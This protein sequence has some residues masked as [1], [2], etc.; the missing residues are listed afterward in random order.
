MQLLRDLQGNT[1]KNVGRQVDFVEERNLREFNPRVANQAFNR[2]GARYPNTNGRSNNT[3][4]ERRGGMTGNTVGNNGRGDSRWS[5]NGR[6]RGQMNN[7]P[8]HR[9][10][11]IGIERDQNRGRIPYWMI[12]NRGRGYRNPRQTFRRRQERVMRSNDREIDVVEEENRRRSLSPTNHTQK[13][14]N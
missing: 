13:I 5:Q 2:E 9:K 10:T 11:L 12:N 6:P 1:N 8:N 4:S 7:G 14:D 3:Y